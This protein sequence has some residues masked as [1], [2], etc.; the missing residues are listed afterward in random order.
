VLAVTEAAE[1]ANQRQRAS[2]GERLAAMCGGDV[3]GKRV[4]LWGLAFKAE[5]DDVRE[6]PAL[7]LIGFLRERGA[8][9]VGY[10]PAAMRTMHAVIGDDIVY[11]DDEYAAAHG[12]D[13]LVVMTDWKQFRSPDFRR[14]H[15]EM[16]APVVLDARNLWDPDELRERGF[17][18]R[19]IGRR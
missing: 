8:T 18:Y 3:R 13:A 5:T 15:R 9:V 11:A 19:G 1:A 17:R 10:D 7:P 12:A 6:T 2:L 4:A 14:L 16:A